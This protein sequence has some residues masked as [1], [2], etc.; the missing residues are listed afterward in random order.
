MGGPDN[1]MLRK[2]AVMLM[3]YGSPDKPEDIEPY[4]TH[5]RGG[6][7][8][9]PQEVENLSRRYNAIGGRS[10][11]IEIT[12][13]TAKKLE[14]K[15][16]GGVKVYAGM[17]HWHPFVSEVFDE[18]THDAITD[19]L[20]VPL[21]PHYSKMSI[22]SYQ[23]AVKNS[24]AAH[25]NKLRLELVNDWYRDDQFVKA[26]TRRILETFD[27]KFDAE[28]EDRFVL[29][30]AHS[31]PERILGWGDPYK[32]QLLETAD[33]LAKNLLLG[34]HQYSFAFQ[35]AGHTAEPWLGPDILGKVRDLKISGRKEVLI[36][37]IGF[38]S[39]HLEILY[40]IDVEAK[41]LSKELGIHLERT[42]SFND[43][44]EF[45]GVLASVVRSHQK[46]T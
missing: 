29:F 3:A 37:P 18:I 33:I 15:L 38:V 35:S 2:N 44:D 4:Y 8:P 39:D 32:S 28:P 25:G 12:L 26:W 45:I 16:G 7:R 21:A 1:H 46:Y 24:N 23:E 36:A 34:S 42:E 22:G 41:Q 43:S 27:R 20:A 31:L 5:I 17:K 19:L 30:T 40:D 9:S 6:R 13:S 11:L 10:P 14:A